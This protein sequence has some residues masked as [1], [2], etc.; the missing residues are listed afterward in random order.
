MWSG[1]ILRT[2]ERITGLTTAAGIWV[3]A[4]VGL[5]VGLGE[6]VIPIIATV[7]VLATLSLGWIKWLHNPE[8]D[9]PESRQ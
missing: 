5:L 7:L 1:M 2:H 6:F 9:S 8:I 4:A 3:T